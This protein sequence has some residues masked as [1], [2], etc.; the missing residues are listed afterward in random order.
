LVDIGPVEVRVTRIGS[1]TFV[2]LDG[3]ADI[4]G[5]ERLRS[6]ADEILEDPPAQVVFD[7]R[8]LRFACIRSLRLISDICDL[9]EAVGVHTAM[10]G[11]VP[12]VARA[13]AL[14]EV[15][16]PDPPGSR[17]EIHGVA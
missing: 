10:S 14:A 3:E 16:L 15:R 4:C 1:T 2:H 5:W 7:M 13:A 17:Y 8:R 9:C 11:V 12:A 6:V